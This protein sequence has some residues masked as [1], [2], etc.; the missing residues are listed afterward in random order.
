MRVRI[1]GGTVTA[2]ERSVICELREGVFR[3]ESDEMSRQKIIRV[4]AR[5]LGKQLGNLSQASGVI[6]S[7]RSSFDRFK[8]LY[9]KG[10]K[11]LLQEIFRRRPVL[12][13]R[14]APEVEQVV[15]DLA[16]EQP[17]CDQVW[18]ANELSKCGLSISAARVRHV[19]QRHNLETMDKRLRTLEAKRAQERQ[20]P[21]DFRR[22]RE[23]VSWLLRRA[24]YLISMFARAV[25]GRPAQ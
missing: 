6:G 12:T 20:L 3:G 15:V 16:I 1:S 5:V 25:S 2:V 21:S 4:M 10:G 13:N 22:V 8:E 23:R 9:D 18:V 24:Q 7:C 17:A 19:W 14:V 11:A